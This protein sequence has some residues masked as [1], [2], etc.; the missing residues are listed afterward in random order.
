MVSRFA[1]WQLVL[2]SFLGGIGMAGMVA[3]GTI[4]QSPRTPLP[5]QPVEIP[6]ETPEQRSSLWQWIE[7]SHAA[8]VRAKKPL[9]FSQKTAQYF[10]PHKRYVAQATLY[11]TAHPEAHRQQLLSVL[12]ITDRQTGTRQRFDSLKE[13]PREFLAEIPSKE[14]LIA[15]L[16]PLGWSQTEDRLLVRQ[17]S[18]LFATDLI[19]D[20]AWIWQAGVG[21][22]A[23]VY[24]TVD[25]Y[26]FA[27]LLGWSTTHPQRV[28]FQTQVMGNPK[29]TIWAVDTQGST[30]LAQS[31][32]PRLYGTILPATA[33]AQR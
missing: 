14:G 2:T 12:E 18:G 3:L 7:Q 11:L 9:R 26:D 13:V 15:A 30:Q 25:E 17:I 28:L 24:P 27:T 20:S 29:V 21:H 6:V 16:V 1:A 10:S 22:V 31:D 23:T 4:A 8:A 19:S 5:D 33:S 32:R